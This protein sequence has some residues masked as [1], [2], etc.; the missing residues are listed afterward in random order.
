MSTIIF[1]NT[2]SYQYLIHDEGQGQGQGRGYV[3][4]WNPRAQGWIPK[5]PVAPA[6]WE[7][8]I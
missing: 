8:E 2:I 1:K 4:L 3:G 7:P 5:G 6:S